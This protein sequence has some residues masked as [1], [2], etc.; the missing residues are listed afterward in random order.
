VEIALHQEKRDQI[1]GGEKRRRKSPTGQPS[2]H[3]YKTSKKKNDPRD[4]K[5]KGFWG[6]E[7]VVLSS[8]EPKKRPSLKVFG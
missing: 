4:E 1:R 7:K 5:K 8:L 3:N 2:K 6:K